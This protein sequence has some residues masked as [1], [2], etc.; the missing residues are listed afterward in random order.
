MENG[1]RLIWM[2]FCFHLHKAINPEGWQ[3]AD[4]IMRILAMLSASSSAV[5]APNA[6]NSLRRR[7][8]PL[9]DSQMF[10]LN[11]YGFI[12]CF[13]PRYKSLV[14]GMKFVRPTRLGVLNGQGPF[15]PLVSGHR[16]SR[17]YLLHLSGQSCQEIDALFTAT[18][19]CNS[20]EV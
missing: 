19:F 3:F 4:I 2:W 15:A 14:S 18:F 16:W 5:R 6:G 11:C 7:P 1:T 17:L 10:P 9:L 20:S 13:R 12:C 8:G